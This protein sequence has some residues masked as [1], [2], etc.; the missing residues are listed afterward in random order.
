MVLSSKSIWI[1]S[2]DGWAYKCCRPGH[3]IA[4]V[5]RQRIRA[6][7]RGVLQHGRPGEQATPTG[8]IGQVRGSSKR[9]KK[10]DLGAI[11][12]LQ[13]C[14]S[15]GWPW[16]PTTASSLRRCWRRKATKVRRS[17]SPV[18]V[19]QPRYQQAKTQ[20]EMKRA[21]EAGYW[22]VPLTK[23][24]GGQNPFIWTARSRLPASGLH[25]QQ[26]VTSRWPN[27]S[28]RKPKLFAIAE[29]EARTLRL[30]KFCEG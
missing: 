18:T 25:Q 26:S 22:H 17:S 13:L 3:V 28:R 15:R 29:K 10:K 8:S 14:T 5:R 9:T 19:H 6:G 24:G 21:V 27:S 1:I 30:L 11:D 4:M 7:Y 16:A 23:L 12:D 2:G 20:A